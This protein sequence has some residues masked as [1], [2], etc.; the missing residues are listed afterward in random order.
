MGGE[1]EA[2][3]TAAGWTAAEKR[4]VKTPSG[5]VPRCFGCSGPR[6]S[7]Q[8]RCSLSFFCLPAAQSRWCVCH[9]L[10]LSWKLRPIRRSYQSVSFVG[11]AS[12]AR[13]L[14][15]QS[16]EATH[17]LTHVALPLSPL[18]LAA[19]LVRQHGGAFRSFHRLFAAPWWERGGEGKSSRVEI[20]TSLDVIVSRFPHGNPDPLGGSCG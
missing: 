18:R 3:H 10:V 6:D 1:E 7:F 11:R 9:S 5:I 19:R 15:R 14:A 17:P 20:S 12:V 2:T 13:S 16:R 8:T 4:Q